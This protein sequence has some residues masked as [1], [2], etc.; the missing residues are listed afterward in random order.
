MEQVL[1]EWIA[2]EHGDIY[3]RSLQTSSPNSIRREARA[4]FMKE[5]SGA[6]K[7]WEI[8]RAM[9][10]SPCSRT[11]GSEMSG[12]PTTIPYNSKATCVK[13]RL[14]EA[15]IHSCLYAACAMVVTHKVTG[16]LMTG[17]LLRRYL[18]RPP[19]AAHPAARLR[20]PIAITISIG[21]GRSWTDT[22]RCF[23]RLLLDINT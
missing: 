12:A 19:R 10:E 9:K 22:P 8:D 13:G 2:N 11:P 6:M 17:R 23:Y 3:R 15:H 4:I 20:L 14:F 18:V 7:K 1:E 16:R 5:P 21:T